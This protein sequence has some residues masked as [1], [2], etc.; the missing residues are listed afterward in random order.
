MVS[1][2]LD[3]IKVHLQTQDA[4]N[5]LYRGTFH[6]LK[7]II[8][9]DSVRG[10]YRGMSSPLGGVAFVNAIVFGVYGNVQRITDNP[11]SLKSH[12]LAGSAAGLIQSFVCSPMELAKTR[13]QLQENFPKATKYKGPLHCLGDIWKKQGLRG[14][15]K[16]LSITAFRDVPG[17]VASLLAEFKSFSLFFSMSLGFSS[18]FVSY[19]VMMSCVQHPTAVH[20]LMAG[21]LAGTFSW[22][23]SFPVDV[24]KSRL[25]ADGMSGHPQYSGIRDCMRKGYQAEGLSFYTRGLCSTLLRAFPMNAACFLV[26][27]WTLKFA[28]NFRLNVN[29]QQSQPLVIMSSQHTPVAGP[30]T[31]HHFKFHEDHHEHSRRRSHLIKSLL[32]F[33]AFSEAVCSAEIVELANDL[34]DD[35]YSYYDFNTESFCHSRKHMED[36]YCLISH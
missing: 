34:Y 1:H 35:H 13:L 10:L 22:L 7:T 36:D 12:F 26:V 31:G 25:Q 19:E 16:G 33:G 21:G 3:T 4:K 2:P 6:C 27:S 23:V 14:V 20:T 15:F 18:Y 9:K 17:K 30:H 24:V 29:I 8:A 28:E 32:F 11:E 5:P